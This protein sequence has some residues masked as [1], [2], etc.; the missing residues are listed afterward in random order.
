AGAP[1]AKAFQKPARL[2]FP[3]GQVFHAPGPS[4]L[5][6]GFYLS[7]RCQ[8]NGNSLPRSGRYD[9]ASCD[10]DPRD[11][12]C[13]TTSVQSSARQLC[14]AGIM[15]PPPAS[16]DHVVIDVRDEMDEATRI[17][18]ALG[19]QLTPIGRHSLGTINHLAMFESNYLELLG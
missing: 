11:D 6:L 3:V 9:D 4:F 19:F 15:S 14:E 12:G 7:K 17:Y 2:L 10:C 18:R 16:L 1:T 13:N 8:A 5:G